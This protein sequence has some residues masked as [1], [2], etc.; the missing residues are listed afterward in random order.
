MTQEDAHVQ[1]EHSRQLADELAAIDQ[2]F[3]RGAWSAAFDLMSSIDARLRLDS[4]G[5]ESFATAAYM[6]GREAT[7]C[8]LLERAFDAHAP[9]ICC[10]TGLK[11][12]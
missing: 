7:F 11:G 10:A 6:I 5:L 1:L 12:R 2:M 4:R 8:E 3:K 9:F